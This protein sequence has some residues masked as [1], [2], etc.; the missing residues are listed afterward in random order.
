LIWSCIGVCGLRLGSCGCFR[1]GPFYRL[2]E[3]TKDF[4]MRVLWQWFDQLAAPQNFQQAGR[5]GSGPEQ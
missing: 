4:R 2:I 3:K 5:R 1:S